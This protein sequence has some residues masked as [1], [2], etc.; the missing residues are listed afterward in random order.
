MQQA[1][2]AIATT[3]MRVGALLLLTGSIGLIGQAAAGDVKVEEGV[4]FLDPSNFDSWIKEQVSGSKAR[5][6]CGRH[7]RRRF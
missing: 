6:R 7:C 5:E 3:M 1:A 4:Y 2:I